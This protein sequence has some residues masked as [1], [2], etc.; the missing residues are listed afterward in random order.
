MTSMEKAVDAAKRA[1]PK[2]TAAL[3]KVTTVLSVLRGLI[4]VVTVGDLDKS[5]LPGIADLEAA[6]ALVRQALEKQKPSG[7]FN[8]VIFLPPLIRVNPIYLPKGTLYTVVLGNVAR[9]FIP[10][11]ADI[12]N[13]IDRLRA[14][15]VLGGESGAAVIGFPDFV[16]VKTTSRKEGMGLEVCVGEKDLF[17]DAKEIRNIRRMFAKAIQGLGIPAKNL[18]VFPYKEKSEKKVDKKAKK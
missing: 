16:R 10:T 11:G 4:T 12:Q 2:E 5:L 9:N 15:L 18:R 1:M 7:Y 6:R 8:D 17:P 3:I 13:A 14:S